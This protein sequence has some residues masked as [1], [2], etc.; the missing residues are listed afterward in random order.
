MR[1]DAPPTI[2]RFMRSNSFGRLIAGPV[3]SGKTT[4][5][6]VELLRRSIEQQPGDDGLRYT[7]WVVARQTLKQL[8]DTVLKDCD[9]WLTANN[10][11]EWRVSESTFLINFQDVRSELILIPLEDAEDQA[12]LLSMQLTGCWLSEAIEMDISVLGPISE[13]VGRYPSAAR[14]APSW[15]GMIADTNMPALGFPWHKFMTEPP[16]DWDIFIQPSGLANDAENLEHLLQTD[17]TAKLDLHHPDPEMRRLNVEAR[18]ATGRKYYERLIGLH[19][20]DSDRAKRY[21]KAEYG[22][23]PSGTAVFRD[24][25]RNS[26][27]VVNDTFLIPGYPIIIGQDFGRDPWSLICQC[28]HLGR[29]IV[30]EEVSAE[31]IGLEIHVQRNLKPR[32]LSD[33]YLG[34]KIAFVGD[35]S[36]TSRSTITEESNFDALKRMGLPCF[37]APTN[38]LDPRL[39][40]VEALLLRQVNGGPAIMI[41]G[42]RCPTLVRGLGG[43]YRYGKTK[44]GL[45]KPIP[46]K[47]E[48]SHVAD[49]LEYVSLT[50]HGGMI[51]YIASRLV[52][53]KRQNQFRVTAKGWT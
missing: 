43:G 51:E 29:L 5:C 18:R 3:G 37:P 11:G 10:I 1:F 8:K 17:V 4:G 42:P 31:S 35:P 46:D 15:Y 21:V 40:A 48:Y 14:G 7:R 41:N 9:T 20:E 19:G 49:C 26:F 27:H 53:R 13:R 44:A 36:G 52:P 12:R 28:D 45:R 2:G 23:D 24:S 16:P 39:R 38:E 30:H 25:F 22:D 47:N 34:F 32:L 50:V 33:R 6:I